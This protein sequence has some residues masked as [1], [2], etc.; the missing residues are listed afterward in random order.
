MTPDPAV[1]NTTSV[2][3]VFSTPTISGF[4]LIFSFHKVRTLVLINDQKHS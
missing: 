3:V 2:F 1:Y 4:K